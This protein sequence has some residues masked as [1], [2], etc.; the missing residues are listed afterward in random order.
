LTQFIHT[1]RNIKIEIGK[2][3][4][5]INTDKVKTQAWQGENDSFQALEIEEG[6]N[7]MIGMSVNAG[8]IP[9]RVPILRRLGD[10]GGIIQ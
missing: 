6:E 9:Q 5:E 8:A 3:K 10:G 7:R 2:V 4:V 1:T